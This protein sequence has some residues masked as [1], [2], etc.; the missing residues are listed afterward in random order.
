MATVIARTA[1]GAVDIDVVTW[2]TGADEN[3]IRYGLGFRVARDLGAGLIELT[4]AGEAHLRSLSADMDGCIATCEDGDEA[5][6]IEGDAY[7][8]VAAA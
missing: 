1:T 4:E 5:M 7:S 8:L 2:L 6:F 3:S